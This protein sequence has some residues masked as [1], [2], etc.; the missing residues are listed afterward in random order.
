MIAEEVG[1]SPIAV[2]YALRGSKK[3]SAATRERVAEAAS[4]MGY[5]INN[6]ARTM[7]TGRHG[8]F[9]LLLS[10]HPHVS[11]LPSTLLEGIDAGVAALHNKLLICRLPDERLTREGHIPQLLRE[12]A[13]DGLLIN[14]TYRIPEAM[15]KLVREDRPPAVWINAKLPRDA[16]HPD[17]LAA[18][19]RAA[20]ALLRAGHRRVV[21]TD[22]AHPEDQ[23]AGTHYSAADRQAGYEAAMRA[24]GLT[25]RVVRPAT[26]VRTYDVAERMRALL[27]PDDRPTAVMSYSPNDGVHALIAAAGGGVGPPALMSFSDFPVEV[28]G[29]PMAAMIV[30]HREVGEEAVA[31]LQERVEH[32]RRR[33]PSRAV[34]HRLDPGL[35]LPAPRG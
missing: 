8:A 22:F 17:D 32:P 2:S 33:L 35:G 9:A 3:V 19:E 31:M 29:L 6:G 12:S 18:G 7:R 4:R 11:T 27:E 16:V 34:A 15:M 25:P 21:Y 26:H 24:A 1:L 20:A 5:R 23:M 14:Y 10:R 13:T 28:T 30:P